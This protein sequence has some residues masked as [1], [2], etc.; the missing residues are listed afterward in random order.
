VQPNL[1]KSKLILGLARWLRRRGPVVSLALALGTI[2]LLFVGCLNFSETMGWRPLRPEEAPPETVVERQIRVRLHGSKPGAMTPL[3]VT[4]PYRITETKSGRELAGPQDRLSR[5]DVRTASGGGIQIGER[6][7]ACGD[8]MIQPQRDASIVLGD[9]TYRGL[10]RIQR[11]GD[12]LLFTNHV[13]IEAYL[14]GVLRGELPRSFHTEAFKTQAVAARTYALYMRAQTASTRSF[15]VTDDESSQVYE[16]VQA[17]EAGAVAAVEAT[18]G[19]VCVWEGGGKE[20]LFCTYYSSSCGGLSQHVNNVKPRDP[21]VPPLAGGV[22]CADC[23][24]ARHYRWGPVTISKAEATKRLLARYPSLSKL[25]MITG[26]R[27][28]ELTKDGRFIRVELVGS[29]GQKETLIGEDFRLSMGGR[30]VKSTNCTIVAQGGNFI[31]K[32]GRGFGHGM[33]LCQ[34]GMDTKARR[35][36]DYRQIL[37]IYYPGAAIKKIY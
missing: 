8:I 20:A 15:D 22:A 28:K 25:G 23:Q 16:G 1:G 33:G 2:T 13:D 36:M 21:N 11:S 6:T 19:E 31:F 26:V 12:G 30:I 32:D 34:H 29:G 7:L 9:K 24:A 3:A 17:E 5:C 10:L 37:Q 4:S 35:G 14:R 18:S 27:P